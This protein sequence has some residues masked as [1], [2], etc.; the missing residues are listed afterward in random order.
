MRYSKVKL[1]R[2]P[3]PEALLLTEVLPEVVRDL[4]LEQKANDMAV[5][6]LWP[7]VVPTELKPYARAIRLERAKTK[8]GGAASEWGQ[9]P[10]MTLW[11]GVNSAS[12]A[13]RLTFVQHEVL[14]KLNT[15]TEQTGIRVTDIRISQSFSNL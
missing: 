5:L 12:A 2:K 15:Y 6:S 3:S 4:N 13:S 11:V 1:T 8:G 7:V 10:K 9:L 14:E